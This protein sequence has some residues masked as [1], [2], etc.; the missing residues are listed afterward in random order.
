MH[1]P[2]IIKVRDMKIQLGIL[3]LLIQVISLPAQTINNKVSIDN[4]LKSKVD[5]A[6]Q[7]AAHTYMNDKR[8]VGLSIGI[9]KD[10]KTYMYNYGE[11]KKGYKKLPTKET[12]YEI[13]SIT[14]TFTGFLLA[15]AVI[16]KS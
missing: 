7:K 12:I 16:E 4:K 9:Y 13:A 5:L 2:L 15:Q 1:M 11:T 14:K 10:G 3:F 8:T 6:V